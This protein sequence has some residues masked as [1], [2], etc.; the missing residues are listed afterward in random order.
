[1]ILPDVPSS[2]AF[3]SS[4]EIFAGLYDGVFRSTDNGDNWAQ[5]NIR[6]TDPPVGTLA[7]NSIGHIFAG[8]WSAGVY[9]ST[10]NGESWDSINAG[11]TNRYVREVVISSSDHIFAGTSSGVFRSTNNGD[12]WALLPG[13]PTGVARLAINAAGYLFLSR[14]GPSPAVYLSTDNGGT[15]ARIDSGLPSSSGVS[16]FAFNSS[17]NVFAAAGGVFRS[18]NNGG[19]WT[20]IN[21]GLGYSSVN[22]VA[23]NSSGYIFAGTSNGVFR[24]V[25]STTSVKEVSSHVPTAFALE[26][27]YPNPF[28]PSTRIKFQVPSSRFVGLKIY[29]LLGQEVA[30]LVNEEMKPGSYEVTWDATGFPS[31]VY[32][33]RLTTDGF[34]ETKKLVLIR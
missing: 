22:V 11:L 32:F 29:N 24:S 17:G 4:G 26:Q 10:N 1:M 20:A 12:S 2:L 27:N 18:T 7:I 15:W 3:N 14:G 16:S 8:T 33:Y 30:S 28:N 9:R 5:V 6:L 25:Q 21:S 23:T 34:L 31:G 19:N 13:S